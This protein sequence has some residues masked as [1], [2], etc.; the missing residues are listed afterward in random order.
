MT[1]KSPLPH[2]IQ[3]VKQK[4]IMEAPS[5]TGSDSLGFTN[6]VA[7]VGSMN[8]AVDMVLNQVAVLE[9]PEFKQDGSADYPFI[10]IVNPKKPEANQG[11]DVT[12][13]DR[14]EFRNFNRNAFHI[15]KTTT[16]SQE[17]DWEAK[18]PFEKFP[19]LAHRSVLIRGPSQDL[20]HQRPDVYHYG[21][22]CPTTKTAHESVRTEIEGNPDRKFSY[23][24][25]VLPRDTQLENY[26][27]SD[28]AVIVK[29]EIK[30]LITDVKVEM[31]DDKDEDKVT[32]EEVEIYGMDVSWKIAKAG[33]TMIRSPSVKKATRFKKR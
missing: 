19:T 12:L 20:W 30:E 16:V 26:I 2:K 18:I 33:G 3:V 13:V 1:N 29:K 6:P 17:H 22:H 27:F 9:Q 21:D 5:R 24:L 31:K 8:T 15:R 32:K 23:W 4:T 14:V 7:S 11:F 25:L 10:V 28:D